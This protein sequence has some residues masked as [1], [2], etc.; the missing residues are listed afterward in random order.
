MDKDNTQGYDKE[1]DHWYAYDGCDLGSI[2][3]PHRTVFKLWSPEAVR[4]ELFLYQDD[5]GPAYDRRD[6]ELGVRGV[7]SAALKESWDG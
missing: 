1:F 6:L 7:W 3:T 2:C 4:V 5:A